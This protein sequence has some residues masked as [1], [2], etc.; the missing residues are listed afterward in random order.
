MKNV[1][2]LL[3]IIACGLLFFAGYF[4]GKS[5]T[6]VKEVVKYEK[7]EPVSGTYP[8]ELLKPTAKFDGSIIDLP[9]YVYITDT[10]NDTI[11]QSVDTSKIIQDYISLNNYN[12]TLFD[13]KEWGKLD[14]NTD[15]QFNSLKRLN[16]TYTP[17][18]KVVTRTVERDFTFFIS[19]SYNTFNISGIGG[20][21]FYHN[22]GVEYEYLLNHDAKNYGHQL[23]FKYKF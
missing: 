5:K 6:I 11:I 22:I 12:L 8:V 9:K 21:L 4:V 2:L 18:Q 20:G 1:N 15:I 7:Q 10:I 13:N 3:I 19:G 16:Y 23:G 14:I 17:M